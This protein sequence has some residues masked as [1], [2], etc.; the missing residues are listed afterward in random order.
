ME[1]KYSLFSP[2]LNHDVGGTMKIE[3]QKV[4]KHNSRNDLLL[5]IKASYSRDILQSD[6]VMYRDENGWVFP[7]VN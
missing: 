5:D 6:V 4:N 1:R 7:P 2:L 3:E